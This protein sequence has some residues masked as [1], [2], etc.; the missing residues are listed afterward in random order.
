MP[1]VRPLLHTAHTLAVC[2][3]EEGL[4]SVSAI[5]LN[6]FNNG[7]CGVH[8]GGG[9]EMRV[10]YRVISPA[11]LFPAAAKA[12]FTLMLCKTMENIAA[13]IC[14]SWSCSKFPFRTC[15]VRLLETE[16]T[17]RE[18][19]IVVL[20]IFCSRIFPRRIMLYCLPR[21]RLC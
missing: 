13:L 4:L 20:L 2:T 3:I 14:S 16:R 10:I 9:G 15:S 5:L 7:S 21:R 19:N 12:L 8:G 11:Y 6:T 17:I 18:L 1:A